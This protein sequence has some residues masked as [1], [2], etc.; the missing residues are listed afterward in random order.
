MLL[1]DPRALPYRDDARWMGKIRG[2]AATRYR[3]SKLDISDCGEKVRK[4]IEEAVVAEGIQILVKQVS[5]FSPDFDERLKALGAPEAKASE[6]EHAIKDEIHVKLEEDPAFYSS[7]RERLEKIVT[8]GKAK[9][10]DAAQ[11]L[12]LFAEVKKDM[13]G[14]ARAA[15]ALGLS[16]SALAMYGLLTGAPPGSAG[17]GGSAGVAGA[18]VDPAKKELASLLE[19]QLEEHV[20]MVD[21]AHKDDLLKQMRSRIK[22]QLRAAGYAEARVEPLAEALVDLLKQRRGK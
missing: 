3:D 15:E 12:A 19:E 13:E 22:R 8:D 9:R 6:M 11:Q 10:I 1:P 2:V 20:S 18:G 4:L 16:P 14:R 5:L 7:L 17:V 21:W